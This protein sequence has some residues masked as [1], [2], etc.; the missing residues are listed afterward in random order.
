MIMPVR[1]I[2]V[3]AVGFLLNVA[4]VSWYLPT[5]PDANNL[6]STP[7]QIQED[8]LDLDCSKQDRLPA[9]QTLFEK[10]GAPSSEILVERF[11]RVANVSVRKQGKPD[12]IVIVG[13]HYDRVAVGCG[14]VDN[15]SGVVAIAHVYRT[16]CQM[17][18]D[19]TIIFVAF[20]KEEQGRVGSKAMADAIEKSQ[21]L[22]YCAMVNIDS[23]GMGRPQVIENISSKKLTA[24]AADLAAQIN[25]PFSKQP[26]Y[27]PDSDS[28]SFIEKGIPSITIHGL[29]GEVFKLI[30]TS[31]DQPK[32]VNSTSEY[33]A[34]RLI[35]ALVSNIDQC[36]CD[37]FR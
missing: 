17:P 16:V 15:W 2:T 32:E 25:V 4:L 12:E 27:G 14:A 13:A 35:L 29:A 9:V 26:I 37:E 1:T 36:R 21:L 11:K 24:R 7:E 8:I 10:M 33:L 19:K 6:L 22:K 30:H 28:S 31:N 23:L 18:T 34:Y 5:Y 20:G 3:F